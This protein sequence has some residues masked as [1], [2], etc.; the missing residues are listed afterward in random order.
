MHRSYKVLV[1]SAKQVSH[2]VSLSLSLGVGMFHEV[3][4]DGEVF[5]YLLWTGQ[6]IVQPCG[7]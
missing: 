3:F 7:C 5:F 4:L 6:P 2:R 1:T